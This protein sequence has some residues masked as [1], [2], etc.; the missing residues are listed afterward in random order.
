MARTT[1]TIGIAA[2]ALMLTATVL[3]VVFATRGAMAR[4]SSGLLPV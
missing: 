2:L 4:N 3:S 1:V